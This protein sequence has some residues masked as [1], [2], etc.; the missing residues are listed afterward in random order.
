MAVEVALSPLM[1]FIEHKKA[2]PNPPS[3]TSELK[4]IGNVFCEICS[5]LKE[6]VKYTLL[7]CDT[8]T[9]SEMVY[10]IARSCSAVAFAL[11]AL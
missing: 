3:A 8:V 2:S 11:C 6:L 9:I 10:E 7:Q 5:T 1:W 4:N